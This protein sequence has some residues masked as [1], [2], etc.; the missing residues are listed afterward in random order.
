MEWTDVLDFFGALLILFGST[1]IVMLMC[2]G[3][4][5]MVPAHEEKKSKEKKEKNN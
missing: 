5:T 1:A 2:L 4:I 3:V